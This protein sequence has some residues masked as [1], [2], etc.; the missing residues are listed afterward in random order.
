M[1][2]GGVGRKCMLLAVTVRQQSST[3]Q[4][5]HYEQVVTINMAPSENTNLRKPEPM[6]RI[7]AVYSNDAVETP[8][9]IF[10]TVH[11]RL[12]EPEPKRFGGRR[13]NSDL[14]T[15]E[16]LTPAEVE[17]LATAAKT[18][19]GRYG[20][21]DAFAIRFAA[22]HGFRASEL[23]ELVWSD[24]E[25]DGGLL[26][27]KRKKHGVAS[28]HPLLGYET[29]A[30]RQ[31]RRDAGE[32]RYVFNGERGP[33]TRAWLQRLV[34][35]CGVKAG[36]DFPV[37]P[38]MLRHAAGYRIANE[39]KDTRSLQHWLGHREIKHTVRYAELSVERFKDW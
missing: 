27:V 13:P 8:S 1:L 14:R 17:K 25:I 21:R 9:A 39:G 7:S 32:S 34:E 6:P 15:R 5:E 3:S 4:T 19:G 24:V 30:L 12:V 28:T 23:T 36:F 18:R 38:H 2:L 20:G 31:L 11:L 37:H 33:L 26:H 35:R 22:R 29:R 10:R 16:Y